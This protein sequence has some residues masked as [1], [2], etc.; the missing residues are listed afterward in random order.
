M[1]KIAVVIPCYN[2][3]QTIAKVVKDFK[4]NLPEAVVYVF[5]NNSSDNTVKFAKKSGAKIRY[6]YKQGKGNVIRNMFR[7]IDAEC[8]LMVDGDDTY[9][10]ENARD[11]CNAILERGIDMV[12]GDRLSSSYFTENSRHF[13]GFGNILVRWMINHI[14]HSN[15][16]DVMTGYR[17]FSYRFVKTFPVIS[18]GFE[19]ETEMTM[20]AL[21][22]NLNIENQII[23]FRD[24]PLGSESKLNTV[25]D[26]A[27]VIA[28][29]INFFKNY[30]P[31]HFFCLLSLFFAILGTGFLIPVLIDYA[32]I[33]LVPKMPTFLVSI[34]F[35]ICTIQSFFGG[36]ILQ[37][38][39]EK[40]KQQFEI[41]LN[42]YEDRFHD[43][44][45]KK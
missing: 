37:N 5:D 23:G 45:R 7:S 15:I 17:A 29:I 22:K 13:H 11:M 35:Y 44:K 39:V 42:M 34:F 30:K 3:E 38:T 16:R 27:K 25:G 40:A 18:R 9:S 19:I 20:H 28:T 4:K 32:E 31:F 6:E 21:D 10:A 36:L 1:D 12:I 24:R 33:G 2:E 41:N 26:G 14:Y 43:F 8:Y